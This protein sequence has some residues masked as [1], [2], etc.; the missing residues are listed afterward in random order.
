MRTNS[1][2]SQIVYHLMTAFFIRIRR[3]KSTKRAQ[4]S[5]LDPYWEGGTIGRRGRV[6]SYIDAV[7]QNS[8]RNRKNTQYSTTSHLLHQTRQD[9]ETII[10]NTILVKRH[11]MLQLEPGQ[12]PL[13]C[14]IQSKLTINSEG[15][16]PNASS[17]FQS[18]SAFPGLRRTTTSDVNIGNLFLMELKL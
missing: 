3:R 13:V 1:G 8:I 10:E 12:H 4:K 18:V 17:V 15:L 5:S 16:A 2:R 14:T 11:S 9:Q 6:G 7:G